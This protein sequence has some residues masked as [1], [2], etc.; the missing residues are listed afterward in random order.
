[1]SKLRGGS[2]AI[3]LTLTITPLH[4]GI[5]SLRKKKKVNTVS[6]AP[7]ILQNTYVRIIFSKYR[8]DGKKVQ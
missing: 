3:I 7:F 5:W 6:K 4:I 1:M 8:V 2:L